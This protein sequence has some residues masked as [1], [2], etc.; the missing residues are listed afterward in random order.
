MSELNDM[1]C[2]LDNVSRLKPDE[3]GLIE[4]KFTRSAL[5]EI[6]GYLQELQ[7]AREEDGQ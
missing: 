4:V 1:I 7:K 3:S 5:K 2:R 6:I